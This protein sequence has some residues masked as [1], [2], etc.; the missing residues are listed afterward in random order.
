MSGWTR[1]STMHAPLI[2]PRSAPSNN[3]AGEDGQNE[4]RVA[5]D[6]AG[7]RASD[8]RLIIEPTEKV[9]AA[10]QNDQRLSKTD[11]GKPGRLLV[12]VP[13]LRAVPKRSLTETPMINS[14]AMS[15]DAPAD[16]RARERHPTCQPARMLANAFIDNVS[17]GDRYIPRRHAKNDFLGDG[18]AGHFAD[19]PPLAHDNGTI[20]HADNLGQFG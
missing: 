8:K 4:G 17:G 11:Q 14:T 18:V 7:D 3:D 5:I 15:S 19:D 1:S 16:R 6:R 2:A 20:G 9:D 10:G 13:R 12:D